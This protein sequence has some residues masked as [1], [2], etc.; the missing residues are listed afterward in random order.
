GLPLLEAVVTVHSLGFFFGY[1]LA[2]LTGGFGRVARTISIE[3]GMQNSGLGAVL[4][5]AHFANPLTA[6]PSAISA[7]THCIIGS[8]LAAWWSR[9][10]P[11][12][13][14]DHNVLRSSV[15]VLL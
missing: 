13:E 1:L 3:V 9:R 5:Q 6:I 15:T 12:S 4:A 10:P 2:G 7:I 14:P 8:A 11:P